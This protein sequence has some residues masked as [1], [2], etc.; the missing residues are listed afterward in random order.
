MK[1]SKKSTT[2][3]KEYNVLKE[4][5]EHLN[6][7][8]LPPEALWDE[9]TSLSNDYNQL[10]NTTVKVTNISDKYHKKL[11][12]AY[13]DLGK[14]K[15]VLEEAAVLREDV[16]RI[17]RHD[18]KTPLNGI[19]GFS[20]LLLIDGP[21]LDEEQRGMLKDIEKCGYRILEMINRSHD[22]YKM[23]TGNY[24]YQANFVEILSVLRKVVDET[25][26]TIKSKNLTVE[27]KLGD[28]SATK[29]DK[30]EVMGE[31]LLCYSMFA[32]LLK[33]AVEASPSGLPVTVFIEEKN[34]AIIRIHN[35]GVIPEEIRSKF[36]DKYITAGKVDGSGLGTYSAKLM[37][38]VQ[39]G[40]IQFDTSE[41]TG[42]TI[43]VYLSMLNED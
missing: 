6:A 26:Q 7:R 36:F 13:E 25:R 40:S 14:Q 27:I 11:M 17:T 1:P 32:N 16:A 42:T 23:E 39:G 35:H 29:S 22:L 34:V 12:K 37:A 9:Y 21:E 10:L 19:I 2:Y 18:I 20:S 24:Q 30:F 38:E 33:N 15:I 28:K 8:N 41:N 4:V 3:K 31:H 43:T 5:Q